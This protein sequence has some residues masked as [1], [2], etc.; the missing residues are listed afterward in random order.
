MEMTMEGYHFLGARNHILEILEAR[1]FTVNTLIAESPEEVAELFRDPSKIHLT[2][3][4]SHSTDEDRKCK[5]LFGSS[6]TRMLDEVQKVH[7]SE[8]HPERVVSGRDEVILIVFGKLGTTDLKKTRIRSRA[9]DLQIDA[10]HVKNLQFNPLKH[11]LVPDYEP[12]PIGSEEEAMIL[13]SVGVKKL[14]SF[15][16]IRSHDIIA[17]ILGLRVNQMVRVITKSPVVRS[18]KIRVCVDG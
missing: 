4:V 7:M 8:D 1:G 12:I 15:P 18:T 13:D 17:R 5:I 10:I 2:Y 6:L 9:L 16:L 11:E 14:R 3:Y